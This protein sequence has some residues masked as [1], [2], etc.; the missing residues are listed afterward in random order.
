MIFQEFAQLENSLQRK[1][2]GT[3]LGLPLSKKLAE[4][5]GGSVSVASQP[6]L[7]STFS[8]AIP[9][10]YGGLQPFSDVLLPPEMD[11]ER[12]PVMVIEDEIEQRLLYEKY[13]RGTGF[14]VA[15][16]RS[17]REAR[18][19]LETVRPA[20]V[21]LDIVLLGEDAWEMLPYLKTT[22]ETAD[23]P[24]LVVT[25]VDDRQKAM[26]LGADAFAQKPVARRWLLDQ[27]R[28]LTGRAAP[29]KILLIDDEEVSRYLLRQLFPSPPDQVIEASSGGEGLRF[30]RD[31]QPQLILLDLVMP[32]LGGFEVLE[33][34]RADPL[35]AEIPVI[36]STSKSLDDEELAQLER[37][38]AG[39]LFKSRLTDGSGARELARICRGLGVGDLLAEQEDRPA[40][41]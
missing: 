24:V 6:G 23:I 18:A 27:L 13:L 22:P 4:L 25:T 5:L 10:V 30:A 3:G 26:S 38:S 39:F 35:T 7:G 31:E 8:A 1:V 9:L 11:H 12:L 33:R 34:L 17:L 36:I 28:R 19:L 2:R 29:R 20:A 16:A 41:R 21:I 15:P 40:E 32:E 37:Y 14:Q